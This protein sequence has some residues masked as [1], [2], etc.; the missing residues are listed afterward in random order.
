MPGR[1]ASPYRK[2]S[3]APRQS[4]GG[5]VPARQRI[6][7][8]ARRH[9]LAHGF[10]G[11]TMD[12]LAQAL[13]MS[14]KTLY[15]HFPS[16]TA[17]LEAILLDKFHSIEADLERLASQRQPNFLVGLHHLL[18]C[19]Q[20][21]TAEIQPPF[22]RDL[23]RELPE[24]FQIVESRRREVVQRYFGKLL[25]QGRSQGLIRK[26]IPL[27]LIVEIL[28]GATQAIMN[29]PKM[30]QLGLT[31]KTG[32]TAIITVILEGVITRKGKTKR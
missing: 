18:A 26:D 19:V 13:G 1:A 23:Q 6:V 29:P 11:V 20:R 8:T 28:L 15:A 17:L 5:A 14:K 3:R 21:H 4:P 22:L 32:F 16:K 25:R 12:D 2:A 27:S 24:T 7:A 30:A 31:P 10:R 9:Y